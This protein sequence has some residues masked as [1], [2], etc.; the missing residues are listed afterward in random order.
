MEN[1]EYALVPCNY[2]K[3]NIPKK[4]I[5]NHKN[6]ICDEVPIECEFQAIGCNHDKVR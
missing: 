4:D 5:M 1:C 2:C 6:K 3:E